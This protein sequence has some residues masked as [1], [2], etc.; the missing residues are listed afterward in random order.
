MTITLARSRKG[1]YK[2]KKKTTD[3]SPEQI[4]GFLKEQQK[5]IHI[6]DKYIQSIQSDF[7]KS[8]V[9]NRY[10]DYVMH[11]IFANIR[12]SYQDGIFISQGLLNT[13]P[14]YISTSL[15]H[16]QR[17]AQECLIDLAYIM[18]DYIRDKGNE[19]LRYLKFIIDKET[20]IYGK[21]QLAEDEYNRIF[22]HNLKLDPKSP[23]QW[24]YTSAKDKIEKGL[25]L[26][27]IESSKFA[28]F[29]TEYHLNLSSGAHG[30]K[31][32]FYTLIRT[33]EENIPML[34]AQL[35]ISIAHFDATL[36][37]ALECYFRLYLN[38][39]KDYEEINKSFFSQ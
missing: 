23:S 21:K 24:S 7:M 9:R 34:I 13:I 35:R 28:E 32:T 19:Y 39:N 16:A 10:A 4:S 29:R 1:L 31:N 3:L 30:N 5:V 2:M 6:I 12:N 38:R 37:S 18:S 26:Y 17:T 14:Y 36:K 33:T 27:N 22:P 25:K 15:Y 11:H 8:P 20:K